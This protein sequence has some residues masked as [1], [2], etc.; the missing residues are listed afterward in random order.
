MNIKNLVS[1]K[2]FVSTDWRSN[3]HILCI[4]LYNMQQ[5][6]IKLL[7]LAHCSHH[8]IWFHFR[9]DTLADIQPHL[10]PVGFQKN[11]IQ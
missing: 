6:P 8:T 9:P 3:K 10:V 1:S 7:T 5:Q 2:S 4:I 11:Y